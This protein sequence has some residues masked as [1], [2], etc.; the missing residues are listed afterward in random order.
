MTAEKR[1]IL[2]VDDDEFI[3]KSFK[4][5][6][7]K[8]GYDVAT[9]STGGEAIKKAQFGFFNVGLFDIRLPDMEGTEILRQTRGS[10]MVKIMVTGYPGM[11]NAVQSLNDGADSY[12]VKPVKLGELLSLI[13]EKLREREAIEEKSQTRTLG[14]M[15]K[16]LNLLGDGEWWQIEKMAQELGISREL[17]KKA[18]S[19]YEGRGL[20]AY[21][22]RNGLVKAAIVN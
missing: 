13:D 21:S 2:L 5:F 6:F 19:F 4:T 8:R 16:Y 10:P 1:R 18:S 17:V 12:V 14:I 9:A 20:V 3:L 7:E 15:E 11:D 22:K